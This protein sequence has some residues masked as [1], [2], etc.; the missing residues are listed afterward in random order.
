MKKIAIIFGLFLI[1][2]ACSSDTEQ[3]GQIDFQGKWVLERMTGSTPNSETTGAE[4][5]WQEYY[6][7]HNDGT[8]IKS[9]DSN[10]VVMEVSGTYR[11]LNLPDGDS[12]ELTHDV[13]N[14]LIG[15]CSSDLKEVLFV[16][17]RYVIASTWMHCDGPGLEYAKVRVD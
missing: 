2:N 11:I 15:N 5:E 16:T 7:F 9:R 13:E 1:F 12:L 8:F 4:M 17:S 3:S 10:G 14:I 6:V